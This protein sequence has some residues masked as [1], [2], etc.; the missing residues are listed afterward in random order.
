MDPHLHPERNGYE[1]Y[2]GAG[3]AYKLAEY[4][5]REASSQEK[6][7]SFFDLLVL[8]CLGTLAD[9]IPLTGD[10]RRLV[11]SG[12]AVI[13]RDSWYQQPPLASSLC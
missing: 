12:L 7:I 9:V 2:C 13:N 11:M 8:A 6:K 1:D 5:C 4:L 10:N 3:L